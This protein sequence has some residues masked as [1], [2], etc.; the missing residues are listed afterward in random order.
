V[1]II[2]KSRPIEI[3]H[4]IANNVH[5]PELHKM[6][7]ASQNQQRV[8]QGN[9]RIL[10]TMMSLSSINTP[11]TAPNNGPPKSAA[12]LKAQLISILDEALAI[13][14]EDQIRDTV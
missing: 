5:F 14:D 11:S 6:M 12:I 3:A 7:K 13:V 4:F 8:Q 10:P 1:H 2:S 9:V